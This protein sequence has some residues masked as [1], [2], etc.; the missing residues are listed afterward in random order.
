MLSACKETTHASAAS[1]NNHWGVPLSL[2]LLPPHAKYA[3]FE[4]GMNHPGEIEPLSLLVRPHIAL[5]LNVEA[6]HL[7]SGGIAGCDCERQ[8]GD[9]CRTAR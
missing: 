1:L 4:L 2:A 7:G 9:L 5:I 6:V 3:I 8:G